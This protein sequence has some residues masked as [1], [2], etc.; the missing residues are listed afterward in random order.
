MLKLSASLLSAAAATALAVGS[1]A[2]LAAEEKPVQG[3]TLDFVVGSNP[4]SYDGHVESTFGMIHPIR[5]MYSLLLRVNPD[6]PMSTTDIICDLCEGKWEVSADGKAY[7]F[8]IRKN[9]KFH[10]GTPLTSADIKATPFANLHPV[11]KIGISSPPMTN[12]GSP[13]SRRLKIVTR[14]SAS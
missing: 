4:P 13:I 3:G 14:P 12:E 7:S 9:V 6:N 10:D 11:A 8:N 1:P 5:P 2:A